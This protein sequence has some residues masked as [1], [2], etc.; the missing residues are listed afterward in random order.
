MKAVVARQTLT[1]KMVCQEQGATM[2]STSSGKIM[3]LTITITSL[4]NQKDI[5]FMLKKK[6]R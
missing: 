3:I 6:V 1:S 4:K 2:F 5:N